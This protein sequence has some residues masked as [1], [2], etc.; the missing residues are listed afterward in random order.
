MNKD[1]TYVGF[2]CHSEWFAYNC[3]FCRGLFLTRYNLATDFYHKI[4]VVLQIV[5]N[6]V[7]KGP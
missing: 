5:V 4:R 7:Y 6:F 2:N 3:N 1:D